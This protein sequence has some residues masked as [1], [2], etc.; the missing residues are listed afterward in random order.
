MFLGL[1][2][3]GA[4]GGLTGPAGPDWLERLAKDDTGLSRSSPWGFRIYTVTAATQPRAA[5]Y[6][7]KVSGLVDQPFTLSYAELRAMT[8]PGTRPRLPVRHRLAGARRQV[9]GRAGS[10]TCSTA[11]ACSPS[12]KAMRF[13]SFD[14]TYT[15]SLTLEQARRKDVLVAYE[16]EGETIADAHG[17]PVRLYVAPMYGYKSIKWLDGIER[18]R[19]GRSRVL[20][21]PRLRRR[22]MGRRSNGRDDEH[23]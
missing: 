11:P 8:P 12:A 20:G 17:G 15:E 6:R 9:A 21:E 2:G 13:K 14:G 7:L 16:I 23:T 22:R 18:H 5:A 10:P 1:L 19:Q 3:V 4:V